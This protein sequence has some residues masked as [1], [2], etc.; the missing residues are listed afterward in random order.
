MK[1]QPDL[2]R[3]VHKGIR[4]MLFE[5]AYDAGR[6]TWNDLR[7]VAVLRHDA[8]SVFARLAKHALLEETFI[9]PL[10]RDAAPEV[11]ATLDGDHFKQDAVLVDLLASLDA[12]DPLSADAPSNGHAFYLQLTSFIG[13]LLMHMADEE[14]RG[15]PALQAAYDADTLIDVHTRL[16]GAIPAEE[17]AVWGKVMLPAMNAPERLALF[18]GLRATTPP[19]VFATFRGIASEVLSPADDTALDRGLV[20][21][22]EN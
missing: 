11:A 15:L 16:T 12:V 7:A 22:A 6:T 3:D 19:P 20:A 14:R 5:L 8:Q 13:E 17:K 4:A 1:S 2:Y 18:A 10:L 21:L 9:S